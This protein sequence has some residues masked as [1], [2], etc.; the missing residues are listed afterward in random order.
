MERTVFIRITHYNRLTWP[1]L[2]S[3]WEQSS[4]DEQFSIRIAEGADELSAS[5][6]PGDV[7]LYSFMTPHLP[8][9]VREIAALQKDIITVAGGPHA[10]ADP[11]G[12][13]RAGFSI[14]ATS[15][16]E[17]S[18]LKLAAMLARGDIGIVR[19]AF[20]NERFSSHLPFSRRLKTI[21]P[22]EMNR[23]C[24]NACL[25][26]AT[27]RIPF[28]HRSLASV[29][30]YFREFTARRAT[31]V[32]FITSSALEYGD[33]LSSVEVLLEEAKKANCTHIEYGI[34]PSELHPK[35][36][37]DEAIHLLKRFVSNKRLTIGLQ[38]MGDERL[39]VLGRDHTMQDVARAIACAVREF[40]VTI[41]IIVALP[42][43]TEADR[44][45]VF[46]AMRD[47][48]KRYAIRFQMHHFFPLAGSAFEN[49]RPAF[50][51]NDEKNELHALTEN[52]I[53]TPWWEEGER[54]TREYLAFRDANRK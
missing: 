30:G 46:T 51:S 6:K 21:P 43:E 14:A 39:A 35:T 26:C 13:I 32:G 9:V 16:G 15:A 49:E 5:A 40:A 3:V 34:F 28:A 8:T 52:G 7:V 33:G 18:M 23:G 37:T 45:I 38:T 10:D 29:K 31:R 41:D 2:L 12:T 44:R 24:K 4:I 19:G 22:L 25:Y 1:L 47:W 48:H 11:E 42:G 36:I 17:D 27:G 53:A 54:T 50:M 20:D